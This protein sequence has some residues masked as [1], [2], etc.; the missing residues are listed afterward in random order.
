MSYYTR[1]NIES[2][3]WSEIGATERGQARGGLRMLYISG[4]LLE[5]WT[6][7]V[8]AALKA[9]LPSDARI[10]NYAGTVLNFIFSTE[11]GAF[12][13]QYGICISSAS[14]EK[15]PEGGLIPSLTAVFS[16]EGNRR[17]GKLSCEIK[18]GN[19]L[20]E[21]PS[22]G[23]QLQKLSLKDGDIVIATSREAW[24]HLQGLIT[25]VTEEEMKAHPE[26]YP[27][28]IFSYIPDGVT[29][30]DTRVSALIEAIL[31]PSTTS[32]KVIEMAKELK[33]SLNK[34]R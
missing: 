15:V 11:K 9:A 29:V 23:D 25:E 19:P 5:L 1:E 8:T 20:P 16:R 17:D 13:D 3:L 24:R 31:T 4:D 33:E 32:S 21:I 10:V 12:R 14:W 6:P 27:D 30:I 22:I 2:Q 28:V 18:E 34:A 7:E 26:R